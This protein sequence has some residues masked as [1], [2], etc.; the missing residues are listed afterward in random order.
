MIVIFPLPKMLIPDMPNN[1]TQSTI[2]IAAGNTYRLSQGIY[3][4]TSIPS[5][6]RTIRSSRLDLFTCTCTS[7]F[8]FSRLTANAQS[9]VQKL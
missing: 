7:S 2:T 1:T 4:S 8:S 5:R 6:G 3:A 9:F